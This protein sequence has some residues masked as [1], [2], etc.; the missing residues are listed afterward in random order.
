MKIST[1]ETYGLSVCF[2]SAIALAIALCT[3][4]YTLVQIFRP[5]FV[6]DRW[7]YQRHLSNEAFWEQKIRPT[8]E[9]S[10]EKPVRPDEETLTRQR[11]QSLQF[12]LQT[13]RHEA[14][15]LL[16]KVVIFIVVDVL[17][18]ASHW[19]IARSAHIG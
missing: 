3:L 11:E 16:V 9:V 17:L 2:V 10:A 4:L 6:I 19:L 13:N 7:D 8:G 15:K 5:R 14:T 1:L 18:F 12:L